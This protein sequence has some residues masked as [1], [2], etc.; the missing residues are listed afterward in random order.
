MYLH[1]GKNVVVTHKSILAVFDIDNSS[2]SYLTREYLYRLE[3]VGRV[4]NVSED[5][6]K[7][8]VVCVGDDG[9]Q[10][11]YLSQLSSAALLKRSESI[12]FE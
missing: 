8:F 1:L 11:A 9:S 2:Q 7:S 4:I 3:K 5:I 12:S 10:T 6:P